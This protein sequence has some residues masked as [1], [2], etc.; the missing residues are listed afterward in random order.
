MREKKEANEKPI[1]QYLVVFIS[2]SSF[3]FGKSLAPV[4]LG[5]VSSSPAVWLLHSLTFAW[6]YYIFFSD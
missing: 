2:T 3:C 5:T 6:G 4:A 1:N